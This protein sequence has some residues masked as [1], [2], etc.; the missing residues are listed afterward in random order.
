M[1]KGAASRASSTFKGWVEQHFMK[2]KMGGGGAPP[3][4]RAC[5]EGGGPGTDRR[6]ASATE[7]KE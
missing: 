5:G 6:G 3:Q 7:A 1:K 4:V 2:K